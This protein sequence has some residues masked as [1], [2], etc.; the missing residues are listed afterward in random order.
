MASMMSDAGNGPQLVQRAGNILKL[1]LL[2]YRLYFGLKNAYGPVDKANLGN[3]SEADRYARL[4]VD[5]KL[6]TQGK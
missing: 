2:F 1:R 6:Q 5:H 3:P 4:I